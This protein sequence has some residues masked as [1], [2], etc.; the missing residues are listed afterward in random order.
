LPGQNFKV[1]AIQFPTNSFRYLRLTVYNMTDDP[2]RIAIETVRSAFLRNEMGKELA[3]VPVK[4]MAVSQDDKNN[5]T[6]L[7]LDVGFRNLPVVNLQFEISTP[8]FY[9]GYE[10]VGRN[11]AKEKVPRKTE[12]R[13]ETMEQDV[14]WTSVQRGVLYRIQHKQKISES[15]KV[16]GNQIPYRYLRLRIFNGDNPPLKLDGVSVFWRETSLVFQAEAGRRYRLIGGNPKVTEANYDLGRSVQGIDDLRPP[17]VNLGPVIA[18]PHRE[19]LP[20]WTERHSTFLW[21]IL[22]LAVGTMLILIV[23]NLKKLPP[24]KKPS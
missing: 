19:Q 24:P 7:D 22:V 8:Y 1:D 4:Q 23:R 18:V 16:E 14:P 17:A 3:A 13:W 6:L 2:R 12:T 20:P 10:L 5:Q 9:R 11:E 21:I 15:I